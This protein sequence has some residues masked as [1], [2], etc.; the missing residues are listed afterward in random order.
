MIRT[1]SVLLVGLLDL[2]ALCCYMSGAMS[3][4]AVMV[5]L[6]VITPLVWGLGYVA[7]SETPQETHEYCYLET[8]SHKRDMIQVAQQQRS[9][10]HR[11]VHA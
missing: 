6:I 1:L 11:R 9:P 8:C 10:S 5:C 2:V 7:G 4:I 3:A